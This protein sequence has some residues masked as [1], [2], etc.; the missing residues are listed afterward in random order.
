[1]LQLSADRLMAFLCPYI[2]VGSVDPGC[3]LILALSMYHTF[4]KKKKESKSG[5]T[6]STPLVLILHV[7]CQTASSGV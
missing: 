6:L 2:V 1:M 7:L 5:T 3:F 4:Q